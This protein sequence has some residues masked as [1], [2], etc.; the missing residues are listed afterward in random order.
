VCVAGDLGHVTSIAEVPDD[1]DEGDSR[2]LPKEL[3][4]DKYDNLPKADIFALGLT[5]YEA[6]G[7][8]PL[9]ANGPLWVKYREGKLPE[10]LNLSKSMNTLIK[11][12]VKGSTVLTVVTQ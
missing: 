11:V 2:Y 12:G 6:A 7:G 3:L 9:P 10:L 5:V 8:G 4:C 1:V